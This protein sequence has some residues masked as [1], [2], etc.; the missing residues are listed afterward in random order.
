MNLTS[1]TLISI[2][3][4]SD[5]AYIGLMPKENGIC[6]AGKVCLTFSGDFIKFL[7]ASLKVNL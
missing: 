5:L 7:L 3:H 6:P 1:T 2:L 4:N